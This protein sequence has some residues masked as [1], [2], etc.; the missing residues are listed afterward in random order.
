MTDETKT[1]S[2]AAAMTDEARALFPRVQTAIDEIRPNLQADGGDIELISITPELK[3][4]VR[5]VGACSGCPSA[6]Y[7]LHY[8]V[9]NYLRECVPEL[10]GI[11][12][13]NPLPGMDF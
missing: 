7:T 3:A 1:N 9:E 5:L 11:E 8:G 4:R 2:E 6:A 12:S 13:V 10:A